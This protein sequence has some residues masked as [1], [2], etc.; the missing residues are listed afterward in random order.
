M[1]T[2]SCA[3]ASEDC[4]EFIRDANLAVRLELSATNSR[5]AADPG[6][7]QQ[8]FRNLVVNAARNSP[9]GSHLTIRTQDLADDAL[10]IDFQ[11]EGRGLEAAR[12]EEIFE[13]FIQGKAQDA[14]GAPGLGLGLSIGRSIIAAHG[15]TLLAESPGP[16]SGATFRIILSTAGPAELAAV[17]GP[18]AED[19]PPRPASPTVPRGFSS[20]RIMP[21]PCA[22]SPC[23]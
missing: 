23:R 18:A 15:G 19:A 6:R 13:P 2:G 14:G 1:R 9:A 20:S 8:V 7:L 5:I 12:L 10:A 21:I 11:D 4:A 22:P 16:G 3:R 17:E